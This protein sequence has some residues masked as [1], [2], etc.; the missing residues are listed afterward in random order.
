MRVREDAG[1]LFKLTFV[2]SFF[3]HP[4]LRDHPTGLDCV[5]PIMNLV[6]PLRAHGVKILWVYVSTL[7]LPPTVSDN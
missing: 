6:P 1:S 2:H 4:D 7:I 5:I 3:L